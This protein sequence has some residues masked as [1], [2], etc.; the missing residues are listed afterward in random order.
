MMPFGVRARLCWGGGGGGGM[1]G[2][3]S[4]EVFFGAYAGLEAILVTGTSGARKSQDQYLEIRS[5]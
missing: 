2:R 5:V 4:A 3:L 1:L